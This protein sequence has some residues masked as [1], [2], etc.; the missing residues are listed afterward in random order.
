MSFQV[1][2]TQLS[3][4]TQDVIDLLLLFLFMYV[5]VSVTVCVTVMP[6]E[7]RKGHKIL[8]RRATGNSEPPN[9]YAGNKRWSPLEEHSTPEPSFILPIK[10]FVSCIYYKPTKT[11]FQL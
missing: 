1:L 4:L 2:D 10:N 5:Y 3:S 8:F 6:R 11:T 7:T 9:P